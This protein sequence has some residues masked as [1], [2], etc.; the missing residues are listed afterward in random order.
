MPEKPVIY[1]LPS[2]EPDER[3]LEL[4]GTLERLSGPLEILVIDDGSR[5]E[6]QYLFDELALKNG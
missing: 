3:I 6:K 1:V 2:L 5:A 4:V